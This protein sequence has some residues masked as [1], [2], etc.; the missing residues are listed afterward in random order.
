MKKLRI[1]A[2]LTAMI[3][4]FTGCGPDVV[5]APGVSG[6]E[7]TPGTPKELVVYVLRENFTDISGGVTT[8]RADNPDI[9]LTLEQF[10]SP[11]EM[12]E[13]VVNALNTNTGPDVVLFDHTTTLDVR[14]MARSG[15]F[16]PL[17]DEMA[18]SETYKQ[19]NYQ[20]AVLDA[21]I[22]DGAQLF[23]P[24]SFF[25]QPQ[26]I[27]ES[28]LAA[29]GL[30]PG[31]TTLEEYYNA[32]FSHAEKNKD[33]PAAV[34]VVDWL[35]LRQ[36][37]RITPAQ[38]MPFTTGVDI[39]QAVNEP[40]GKE[41]IKTV[42]DWIKLLEAQDEKYIA[43]DPQAG[44]LNWDEM[45]I[46][47]TTGYDLIVGSYV[48]LTPMEELRQES[49]EAFLFPTINSPT[50]TS[51]L[52]TL[53][54]AATK[55]CKN[56]GAAFAFMQAV[57]DRYYNVRVTNENPMWYTPAK[58]SNNQKAADAYALFGG[59]LGSTK[60][61]PFTEEESQQLMSYFDNITAC[62]LPDPKSTAFIES[63]FAPY[64]SGAADFD[65]CYETFLRKMQLYV[66]E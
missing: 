54:A 55:D 8:F 46:Y 20:P 10:S 19:E 25:A 9:T 30:T 1:A 15:A 56:T 57:A 42:V 33:D 35:I 28:K 29:Y 23:F 22:I 13:A 34:G 47:T 43:S 5:S 32:L 65:S 62:H 50:E 26:V 60:Y 48:L 3:M 11:G 52:A 63:E 6:S 44:A 24:I 41:K 51:S 36:L 2:T 38:M 18:A 37:A 12:D 53:F 21:G 27:T 49:A 39:Q 45:L 14:K 31:E 64:F 59:N 7:D 17:D 16:L 4:L 61:R 58:R 40:D 66:N